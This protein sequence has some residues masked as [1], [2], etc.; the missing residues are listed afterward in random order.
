MRIISGSDVWQLHATHGLPL[1]DSLAKLASEQIVPSWDEFFVA[2]RNDGAN[3]RTLQARVSFA[4]KDA[5]GSAFHTEW[6]KRIDL[7]MQQVAA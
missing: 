4:V 7:L 6:G 5:Y 2:A 3:L 1:E